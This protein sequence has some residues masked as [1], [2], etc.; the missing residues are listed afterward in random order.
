MQFLGF[1][2]W[3]QQRLPSGGGQLQARRP[4][5]AIRRSNIAHIHLLPS[6]GQHQGRKV[7]VYAHRTN[8]ILPRQFAQGSN[9]FRH[10]V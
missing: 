8:G 10:D 4:L 2:L 7:T 5:H 6:L 3:L 1:R 9:Q